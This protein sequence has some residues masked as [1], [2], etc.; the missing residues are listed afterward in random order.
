MFI[1]G[2]NN[3]L[4]NS[5]SLNSLQKR[6]IRNMNTSLDALVNKNVEGDRPDNDNNGSINS[7]HQSTGTKLGLAVVINF[8]ECIADSEE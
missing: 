1:S 2:S 8:G 7:S 3:S 5:G 4:K 6:F